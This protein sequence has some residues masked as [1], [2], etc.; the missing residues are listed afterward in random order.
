M[1][2]RSCLRASEFVQHVQ[3]YKVYSRQGIRY[4]DVYINMCICLFV[5]LE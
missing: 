3:M 5:N 4:K 2:L 1:A